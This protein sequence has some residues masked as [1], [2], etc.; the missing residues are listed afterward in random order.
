MLTAIR[1]N[2]AYADVPECDVCELSGAAH[3]VKKSAAAWARSYSSRL[4]SLAKCSAH[5]LFV[6][7]TDRFRVRAANYYIMR[8]KAPLLVGRGDQ[9]DDD[10]DGGW[11]LMIT[12]MMMSAR[13]PGNMYAQTFLTKRSWPLCNN[14]NNH[15]FPHDFVCI[16]N[17]MLVSKKPLL[18]PQNLP[19]MCASKFNELR[20]ANVV[21]C[22]LGWNY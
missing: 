20:R 12:M 5:E 14:N 13:R 1:G 19:G 22:W 15:H 18:P 2:D 8:P 16:F 21:Y 17:R 4:T 3:M 11:W 10:D 6:F 7:Q 9:G